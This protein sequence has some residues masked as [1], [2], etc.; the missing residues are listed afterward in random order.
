M[1]KYPLLVI[2]GPTAVGKTDLSLEISKKYKGE[3]ISADSMQI[4][5]KMNIGTAKIKPNEMNNIKHHM[6]DIINPDEDFSVAEY[7][8]MVDQLIPEIIKR[9]S[10]PI[11]V[12]GTGLYIKSVVQGFIFPDMDT[13]FKLR[14]KLEEQAEKFGNEYIHKKLR[15]IDPELAERLHPNDLRRII[16]GIEIYKVTG[17]TTTYFKKKQEKFPPRYNTLKIGL[18][19]DRQELYKR[20]NQRVDIMIEQGLVDEVKELINFGY[21]TESTAFQG[22]GY[23][24]IVSYFENECSL[25]EAVRIL[26]RDTR[27]FAKRQ[28]TWFRRDHEIK[29]INLTNKTKTNVIK[30]AKNKIEDWLYT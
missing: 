28:L 20:I 17:H 27:H 9:G 15:N 11:M 3:I 29:W 14:K 6:I 2:L 16:R 12:G 21:N 26:K 10:L 24:E 13:D 5:R 19:R 25:D 18:K 22:L 30:E 1:D 7:Q 23:K 8:E 4:Y